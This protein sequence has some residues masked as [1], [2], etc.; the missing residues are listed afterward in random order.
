VRRTAFTGEELAGA[1]LIALLG[2]F[3]AFVLGFGCSGEGGTPYA[4]PASP[5]GQ[6]C[7]NGG[8][9]SPLLAIPAYVVVLLW[10]KHSRWRLLVACAV[11]VLV[12]AGTM[13]VATVL[14]SRCQTDDQGR[15]GCEHS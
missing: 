9:L 4:A 11:G 1:A 2:M 6:F 12:A 13:A 3:G 14:P 5:K 7:Q 10:L 8:D 15:A